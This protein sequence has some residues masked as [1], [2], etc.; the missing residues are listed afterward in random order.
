MRCLK[1]KVIAAVTAIGIAVY[2][3]APGVA[4]A[5]VPLLVRV[6]G[7]GT[8]EHETGDRDD[9]TRLRA[10]VDALRAERESN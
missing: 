3:F 8:T 5:A 10:E 7:S 4:V 9:V 1:W 2:A 6:M